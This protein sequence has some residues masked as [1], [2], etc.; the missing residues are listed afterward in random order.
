VIVLDLCKP[1]LDIAKK[2]IAHAGWGFAETCHDDITSCAHFSNSADVVTL[3]YSLTMIPRWR[4][5]LDAAHRILRPG[6][7]IGIVDFTCSGEATLRRRL[8]DLAWKGWFSYDGVQLSAQHHR[9]ARA[10]FTAEHLG[11]SSS[12]IPYLLGARAPTYT[13]LGRRT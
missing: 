12:R 11:F 13:F 9:E 6:A 2:R 7:R 1:L 4:E 3:C 8:W 10:R 5:A